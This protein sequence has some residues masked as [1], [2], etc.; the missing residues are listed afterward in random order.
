VLGQVQVHVLG[1]SVSDKCSSVTSAPALSGQALLLLSG[2]A[3]LLSLGER[4]VLAS[5]LKTSTISLV[6]H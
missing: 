3:L 1:S 4:A 2:Q 5:A 6:A